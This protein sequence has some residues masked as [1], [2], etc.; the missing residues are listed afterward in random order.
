MNVIHFKLTVVILLISMP[1]CKVQVS[2]LLGK[3]KM[4][5]GTCLIS[6]ASCYI[7]FLFLPLS[8]RVCGNNF[9]LGFNGCT[10]YSSHIGAF[11]FH[12]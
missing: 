4:T 8:C 3:K 6:G 10:S 9:F 5:L 7:T 2:E 11:I 1:V 12:V